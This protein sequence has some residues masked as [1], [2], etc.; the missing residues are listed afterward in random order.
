MKFWINDKLV[1]GAS[2]LI[3]STFSVLLYADF[4]KKIDAGSLKQIGTITFKREVAQRK[5]QAQVV[6][7]SIEQNFPVFNNDSIRTSDL[8]EAVIHLLDGTDINVDENSMIMLS[9]LEGGININ[10][11]HG[12]ISA[13]RSGVQGAD[14]A[15]INIKS[16]DA[17]VSIDKS[18]IQLTQLENKEL[19]LTVSDG[20]AKVKS[21]KEET[22]V[23]SSEKALI[24]ADRKDTK[25]L[26]LLFNLKEPAPNSYSLVE[27]PKSE[28]FFNWELSGNFRNITLEVSRDRSFSK[29]IASKKNLVLNSDKNTLEAGVY[30]WRISALNEDNKAVEYSEARKFNLIYRKPVKLVTPSA[31]EVIKHSSSQNSVSFRWTEDELASEYTLEISQ[32]NDFNSV[33]N[34]INTPL[35]N[36]TIDNFTAGRYFWRITSSITIGGEKIFKTGSPSVFSIDKAGVVD[37]PKLISPAINDKIDVS[38]VKSKGL[39]LSWNNDPAFSSYQVELAFDKDFTNRI[40]VQQRKVNFAEIKTDISAGRYFWRVEGILKSG[41]KAP[42]SETGEFEIVVK[43]NIALLTPSE[44]FEIKIPGNSKKHDIQFSWLK[45]DLKGNYKL[46]ISKNPEFSEYRTYNFREEG[47]GT[48]PF[49]ETGDFFWRIILTNMQNREILKSSTSKF[50]VKAEAVIPETKTFIAVKSP[51]AGAKIFINSKFSGYTDIKQEVKPDVS[52]SVKITATDFADFN[53]MVKVNAGDTFTLS[54]VME[55]RKKLERIKWVSSLAAPVTAAPLYYK[56]R[57]IVCSENGSVAVMN[58]SGSLQFSKK[59]AK[60]FDSRPAVYENSIY[61]VDINGI[62]YSINLSDGKINWQVKTGGPLLFKSEPAVSDGKIF[63]A[64]GF[65]VVEAYDLNGKKVWENNLNEAI[66]NSMLIVKNSLIIA[67]DALK[68]YSL[69]RD[70]GDKNW[71]TPID[72]KVITLRPLVYKDILYFGCYSGM[73]YAIS[74][75]KGK[76]LWTYKTAGAIYS[77]PVA[78]DK[79]IYFGSEDGFIYSLED[80]TGKVNWQYKSPYPVLGSPIYAFENIF[81][82]TERSIISL[83]PLNG[84][85]IWQNTFNNKVKTSASLAGDSLVLGLTNGDVVSVRNTLIELVQ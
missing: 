60:R 81:V 68:L 50:T 24:S 43:E 40:L 67:T 35:K 17:T 55:K 74:V 10:F 52:V 2:A 76:I 58:K 57:I 71:T 78:V 22:I 62:L 7:E 37:P 84:T 41:E 15:A 79:S 21:G 39:V 54:P 49:T 47:T 13:N 44:N 16:Q 80:K 75:D 77:T 29:I 56:D 38:A 31:D 28:V 83:N 34:R 5:Y 33:I 32:D 8:S 1:M 69:D 46:Q 59:I 9:T 3:I 6:W 27:T 48:V 45:S 73:F 30:Y 14:I 18:N 23:K 51:V 36:I 72:E 42:H 19:D 4:H 63:L 11:D 85:V 61:A 12:S 66:Y 64:N 65:G 82:T 53:T 70:D 25:V 20:T 26:K